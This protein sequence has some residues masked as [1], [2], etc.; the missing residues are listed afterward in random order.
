MRKVSSATWV[1]LCGLLLSACE[2][3]SLDEGGA[4]AVELPAGDVPGAEAMDLSPFAGT[5][6]LVSRNEAGDSV[7]SLTVVAHAEP[8]GWTIALP[9]RDPVPARVVSAAGDSVVLESGPL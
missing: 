5:W 8:T 2:T 6:N 3:E 1:V 7:T 9:G 4:A